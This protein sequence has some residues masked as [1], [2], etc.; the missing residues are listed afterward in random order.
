M[1]IGPVKI[2][3]AQ[4]AAAKKRAKA[5]VKLAEEWDEAERKGKEFENF[6]DFWMEI[7]IDDLSQVDHMIGL[8][9]E[10]VD[11][12][13]D[14]AVAF[15]HAPQNYGDAH[16]RKLSDASKVVFAGEVT[17]GDSPDGDGYAALRSMF[18]LGIDKE[19]GV[20]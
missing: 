19:L 20:F 7:G 6:P 3:D 12:M 11:A 18:E 9:D 2:S 10:N 5:T 17:W 4:V 15:W 1:C 14:D 8:T 16:F 13:V